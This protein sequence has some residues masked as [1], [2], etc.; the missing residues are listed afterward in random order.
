MSKKDFRPAIFQFMTMLNFSMV[1]FLSLASA[2]SIYKISRSTNAREFLQGVS[3]LP[4]VP[5]TVPALAIGAFLFLILIMYLDR[6]NSIPKW[7]IITLELT[8]GIVIM[9]SLDMNYN[10]VLFLITA[11][12]LDHFKHDARKRNIIT[13]GSVFLLIFDFPFCEKF[14][15]ITSF[16]VYLSYYRA[17][18]ASILLLIKNL[19]TG[20][21]IILFIVY[22]ILLLGEQIDENEKIQDLN[23]QLNLA[24]VELQHAN[25][26]LEN[27]AKQSE[28]IAQTNERNRLAR[29]I[30]DT[31]GHTLTGIIAG[32]DA[33]IAI[34]PIST[35]A[36]RTQLETISDAARQGMTDVRRSVNALRP[37]VL[38]REDLLSAINHTIDEM[39]KTSNVEIVFNN[40]IEKLRF[41]D[42][43]EDVI[44]RII[45]EGITNAIRHG[46]AKHINVDLKKEYSIVTLTISDDG[47]GS[48]HIKYGFGLTHMQERLDMLKGELSVESNNGFTITAQIPIRWGED[49]D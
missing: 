11:N 10:G 48:E 34:L 19:G 26:E 20:I 31:L 25:Q 9:R 43:E 16:E 15:D 37:D 1:V 7:I 35:E 33:A 49:N 30:H 2:I 36:T 8:S 12:L 6:F 3:N 44:Y 38:E 14:M 39:A 24:N 42:D 40:E 46:K 23:Q 32:L 27:Y 17:M 18:P 28:R 47:I 45:Q 41:N 4:P 13:F 22:T 5:W 21:N 29:E